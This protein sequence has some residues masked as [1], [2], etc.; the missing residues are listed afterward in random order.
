MAKK[1]FHTNH[2]FIQKMQRQKVVKIN[3]REK[4]HLTD[5]YY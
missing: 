4:V 2:K 3:F 1:R 5:P